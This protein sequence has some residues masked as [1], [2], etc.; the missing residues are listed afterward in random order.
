MGVAS[1]LAQDSVTPA[2]LLASR[3]QAAVNRSYDL[4]AKETAGLR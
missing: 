4:E 1:L 2:P 3:S